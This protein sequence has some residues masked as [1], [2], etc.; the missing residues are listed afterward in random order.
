MQRGL[1]PI[2]VIVL[3]AAVLV[4]GVLLYTNYSRNQAKLISS[5]QVTLTPRPTQDPT[6]NWKIYVDKKYGFSFQYPSFLSVKED[7]SL[8]KYGA[9]SLKQIGFYNPSNNEKFDP[10]AI[11][12]NILRYDINRAKDDDDL[13][14]GFSE[15]AGGNKLK[16]NAIEREIIV[17]GKK[18]NEFTINYSDVETKE[19]VFLEYEILIPLNRKTL[20]IHLYTANNKAKRT[21]DE[22][23]LPSFKF[24]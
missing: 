10:D 4:G 21:I 9:P 7:E 8:E 2:L 13:K 17:G 6:A 1:V 20:S 23:I 3:F 16:R 14:D 11:N 5:Q 15:D 12:M 24:L 22:V 18:G 19:A